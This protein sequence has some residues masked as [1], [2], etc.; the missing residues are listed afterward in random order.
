MAFEMIN[1]ANSVST[2]CSFMR[3][4][5]GDGQYPDDSKDWH[6][7]LDRSMDIDGQEVVVATSARFDWNTWDLAVNQSWACG[8]GDPVQHI[9]TALLE[10]ECKE[11]IGAFQYINECA[12]PE[13]QI[14]AAS[15]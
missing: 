2:G 15:Q 10:P 12:A 7:C 3:V 1:E 9:A 5:M 11:T 6:P 8:D 4:M 14:P 13:T